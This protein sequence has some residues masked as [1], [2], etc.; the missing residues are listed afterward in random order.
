MNFNQCFLGGRLTRAPELSYTPN[1]TAVV[2]FGLA[3]NKKWRGK[4]GNEREETLF[5]DCVAFAKQAE[6]LNQYLS[7]GDPLFVQGRLTLDTWTAQDGTKRSKHYITID[8]F[9]FVGGPKKEGFD[10]PAVPKTGG[11]SPPVRD[12]VD[13]FFGD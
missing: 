11:S 12:E 9:Q 10:A 6:T 2:K 5:V 7:K 3:T 4:D 1:T 13:D 8:N